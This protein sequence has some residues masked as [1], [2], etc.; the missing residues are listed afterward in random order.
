[1]ESVRADG[2]QQVK[3]GYRPVGE[4]DRRPMG[5]CGQVDRGRQV[6]VCGEVDNCSLVKM[7]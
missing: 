7:A 2:G 6:G 3:G 5:V 1:M 4:M